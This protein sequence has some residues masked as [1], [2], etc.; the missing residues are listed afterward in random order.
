LALLIWTRERL[1]ISYTQHPLYERHQIA[2]QPLDLSL[3]ALY[4]SEAEVLNESD[5]DEWESCASEVQDEAVVRDF[6]KMENPN[7]TFDD[8]PPPSSKQI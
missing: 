4:K 7:R 5:K 1:N 3:H 6:E 8:V 2:R